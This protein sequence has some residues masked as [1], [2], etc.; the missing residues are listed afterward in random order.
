MKDIRS[1]DAAKLRE[2]IAE[3]QAEV[4][5]LR[6]RAAAQDLKGVRTIRSA[7]QTLARLLTRVRELAASPR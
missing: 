4:R 2:L 3:A 5:N 7:R 6:T 1:Y